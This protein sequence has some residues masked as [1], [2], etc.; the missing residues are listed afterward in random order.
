MA[1]ANER[2]VLPFAKKHPSRSCHVHS[3]AP[4]S[5]RHRRRRHR[6]GTR[7]RRIGSRDHALSREIRRAHAVSGVHRRGTRQLDE[8]P[9][10]RRR[11]H[12]LLPPQVH[13]S[14]G[15]HVHDERIPRRLGGEPL[16]RTTRIRGVARSGRR[17][18]ARLNQR[19]QRE[20][21][22][23]HCRGGQL[24]AVRV[25]YDDGGGTARLRTE[26]DRRQ[27]HPVSVLGVREEGPTYLHV[28]P[29]TSP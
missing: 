19:W 22:V 9:G 13:E 10:Q 28:G 2:T 18:P 17:S 27:D 23:G 8:H 4:S 12:D 1:S 3:L 24:H 16:E 11:R 21:A 7:R 6:R 26:S 5:P 25:S 20:C 15:S 14:L 29:V